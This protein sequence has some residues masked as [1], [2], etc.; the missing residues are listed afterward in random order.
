MPARAPPHVRALPSDLSWRLCL[1]SPCFPCCHAFLSHRLLPSRD[2]LPAAVRSAVAAALP[3]DRSASPASR[4]SSQR[5]WRC[6]SL[7]MSPVLPPEPPRRPWRQTDRQ[8]DSPGDGRRS[9]VN[10]RSLV[11]SVHR[12]QRN[13]HTAQ[14]QTGHVSK[15]ALPHTRQAQHH[16][17][18]HATTRHLSQAESWHRKKGRGASE[19]TTHT[20]VSNRTRQGSA[21]SDTTEV[22]GARPCHQA[23]RARRHACDSFALFRPTLL[24]RASDAVPAA[25]AHHGVRDETDEYL[26]RVKG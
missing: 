8:T 17:A 22:K 12:A 13:L 18:T 19:R 25:A 6:R 3:C 20:R 2:S 23:R 1:P 10:S 5:A 4:R 9:S 15:T 14:L 16:C 7:L 11:S 24:A 21:A 26:V